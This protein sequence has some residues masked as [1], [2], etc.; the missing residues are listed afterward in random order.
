MKRKYKIKEEQLTKIENCLIE[1]EQNGLLVQANVTLKELA[2][3]IGINK[4]Y[5]SKYFK[6]YTG[7]DNFS[8]YLNN[9]RIQR[10]KEILKE[11]PDI[12]IKALCEELGFRS[13][14]NC[15]RI[16]RK[17]TGKTPKEY[18]AFLFQN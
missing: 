9:F 13:R 6:H 7:Y 12:Q 11:Q 5:L 14:N 2:K 17:Y 10:A 15:H 3:I 8:N 16:F 1:A 18:V 4:T